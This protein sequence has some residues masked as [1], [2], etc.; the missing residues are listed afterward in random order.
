AALFGDSGEGNALGMEHA[1]CAPLVQGGSFV[2]V[3]I[4]ARRSGRAFS[5]EEQRIAGLLVNQA[6]HAFQN[7]RL[8]S[9]IERQAITDDL[10]GLYNRG[11]FLDLARRE[12]SRSVRY[13]S[14]LSLILLDADHF[15]SIN[16]L[17]GHQAG[18]EV[19]RALAEICDSATRSFDIVGRYGGEEFVIVLPE[20]PIDVATTVARRI[21]SGV[22]QALKVGEQL[23]VRLT[24]SAGV[25]SRTARTP[26]LLSLINTAD[27]ALYAAKRDGR[28][29][30]KIAQA[31][32]SKGSVSQLDRA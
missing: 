18:D 24:I 32:D 1:L 26:D 11:H 20:T 25:A 19:L 27:Q 2:G 23:E 6:L 12:F 8:Y 5:R 9:E 29:Q 15:K 28:N 30:V 7:A 13:D 21:R 17:H 16:D 14:E 4:L 10:T 22:D 31:D 3:L